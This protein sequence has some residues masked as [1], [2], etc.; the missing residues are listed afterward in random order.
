M[1]ALMQTF[2]FLYMYL[3]ICIYI[4]IYTKTHDIWRELEPSWLCKP[5]V[6]SGLHRHVHVRNCECTRTHTMVRRSLEPLARAVDYEGYQQDDVESLHG[7]VNCVAKQLLECVLS[8]EEAGVAHRYACV[9]AVMCLPACMCVLCVC[10]CVC[11][12]LGMVYIR[13]LLCARVRSNVRVHRY[14][15]MHSNITVY[16]CLYTL[17]IWSI[18]AAEMFAISSQCRGAHA[19]GGVVSVSLC[20]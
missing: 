3:F 20:V 9:H 6:Q 12:C 15:C 13:L 18:R 7:L 10:V 8:L 14:D 5:P 4:Y 16:M 1:H 11:V 19:C 17:E 2:F